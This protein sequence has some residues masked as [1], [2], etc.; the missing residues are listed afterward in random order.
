MSIVCK[1]FGPCSG[2]QRLLSSEGLGWRLRSKLAVRGDKIG[3]FREHSHEVLPI[4]CCL[5]H[6]PLINEV[7]QLIHLP[8]YD[9]K[10]HTGL[11]RY[12]QLDV[13]ENSVC[14]ALSLN[15]QQLDKQ[16][17]RYLS[18]LVE[19]PL[20]HSLWT[21][22][23]P[24]KTNTI[25]SSKWQHISGPKWYTRRMAGEEIYLSPQVFMQPNWALFEQLVTT[26]KSW[27]A[28]NQ[29]IVEFYAGV[30]TVS[31]PLSTGAQTLV[32][33]E[34]NPFAEPLFRLACDVPY[35]CGDVDDF[36]DLIDEADV[37]IADPPRKGLSKKLLSKICSSDK[38]FYYISCNQESWERD[39][40]TL[41][42][43]GW[44]LGRVVSY[45][46]I[47][48]TDHVEILSEFVNLDAR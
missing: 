10:S 42:A 2:C 31:V 33:V 39:R 13:V 34:E 17:D 46:M 12:I 16:T 41:L 15:T 29:R 11:L 27:I 48:G 32:A 4:P 26:L 14:V 20:I 44:K 5:V 38:T 43:S 35:H 45:P 3:L 21:N 40:D 6:H 36:I 23:N 47:P 19:N 18:Q 9:E 1:H 8:G 24:H 7:S 28:E 30:G 22:F 25:F 37:I